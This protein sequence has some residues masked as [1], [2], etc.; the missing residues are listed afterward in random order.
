MT[1]TP[2]PAS[3]PTLDRPG[4]AGIPDGSD[5]AAMTAHPGD[6]P[7][8]DLGTPGPRFSRSSPYLVGFLGGLG[9][10]TAYALGSV[11]WTISGVLVQVLVAFFIAAGL[12]PSVEWIERRGVR[13]S[14]AVLLVI[15]GVL[16]ALVLFLVAFVPVITDQ[17]AAITR[18]APDW[19]DALQGNR[20]VQQLDEEYQ[21]IEKVRDYV[22]N[23]DFVSGLF[24]GALGVGLAVIG[25]LA[26][27]FVVTVMT[28]YFLAG[29]QSTKNALYRLAPA[30]RRDR[31]T[32][33]GDRVIRGIGGYVSGAFIVA[34]C[35][36]VSSLIFL[37]IVGMSEYA[38]ALAF[39]VALLDVIPMIGATLGAVIVS[40]IGFA[41][42]LRIGIACVIFYLIYQQLENY[43]IYP[44][45]MSKSVDIPGAVTVIAALV[46]A[47]LL[48]VVG[49]LLAI[50]TA[51]AILMLVREMFVRQQDAS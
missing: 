15:V 17:V 10:L 44:R 5:E 37:F 39:V 18:N 16:A 43:V 7:V 50:P 28:L 12:N 33:L 11:L 40:A 51:A 46:G 41:T 3:G 45:V 8:D 34:M 2:T 21:I 35:A 38:V 30:S 6:S 19:L 27:A 32:K 23:G 48:G 13:R 9:L 25:A 22:T 42:D 24:G 20:R 47:S 4:R 49:A 29:M 1:D 26:N 14:Y 36:G 31:V